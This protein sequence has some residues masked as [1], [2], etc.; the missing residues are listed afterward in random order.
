MRRDRSG[1]IWQIILA[2]LLSA[3]L[4]FLLHQAGPLPMTISLFFLLAWFSFCVI[5]L[6]RSAAIS[7]RSRPR[8]FGNGWNRGQGE[9][10]GVR[11]PRRPRPP[12]WPPRAAAAIPEDA[13]SQESG[14]AVG[15]SNA[16]RQPLRLEDEIA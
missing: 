1:I 8:P 12:F 13:E 15:Y 11:E 2:L 16:P 3:G 9:W 10:S 5:M 6:I 7:R 4:T 14:S